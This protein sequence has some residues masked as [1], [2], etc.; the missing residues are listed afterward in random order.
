G[1]GLAREKPR[2]RRV[3]VEHVEVVLPAV[4]EVVRAMIEVQRLCGCRPQD[5][6]EL[7]AADIDMSGPVWEYRP[8]RYKTEHHD[9]EGGPDRE[10]VVFLGPHAQE[11]LKPFFTSNPEDFLFSPRRSEEN[12]LAQR[13]LQRKTPP[14]PSHASYQARKKS[15][16][17]RAPLRDRYDVASFRRAIR[18]ACLRAGIPVWHP[19]QL[20]HTCLTNIRKLYGLEASKACAGHREIGVTQHYAERGRDGAR[21]VVADIG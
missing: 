21:G 17:G 2:V 9:D 20:R 10:R 19:N 15:A 4:P 11:I 1:K 18:R 3:R 8:R 14:W 6:V 7:R 16:R 13:R 5:V 12:R